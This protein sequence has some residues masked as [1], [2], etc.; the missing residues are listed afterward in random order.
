MAF[1]ALTSLAADLRQTPPQAS[2][3]GG[4]KEGHLGRLPV[5]EVRQPNPPPPGWSEGF[6]PRDG[7]SCSEGLPA[8]ACALAHLMPPRCGTKKAALPEGGL[9]PG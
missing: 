2:C 9:E 7:C 8:L 1:H 5:K 4:Q 3:S 6:A